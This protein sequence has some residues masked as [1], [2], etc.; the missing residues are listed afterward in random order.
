MQVHRRSESDIVYSY[1]LPVVLISPLS[2]VE[3]IACVLF[4]Q[5]PLPIFWRQ[6]SL[7]LGE[8]LFPYSLGSGEEIFITTPRAW[9]WVSRM[10]E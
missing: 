9:L 10:S 1:L 5:R 3:N 2:L 7:S 4:D 8:I 6:S